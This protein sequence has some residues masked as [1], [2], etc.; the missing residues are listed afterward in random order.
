MKVV[1]AETGVPPKELPGSWPSYPEMFRRMFED[2]GAGF[3]Y[4]TYD[5]DHVAV[6]EPQ[7]GAALLVTGSPRGVYEDH[8]FIPRLE[9]SVR[10]WAGAGRPVVGICFGHQLVARAFGAKVEKSERGW[11]VGVHT[12]EVVGDAPWGEGPRRFACAVSHQDQVMGLAGGLTRIAGS[13]FTPY[14]CL[15]HEELPVL[16][17]Q[18]HPEFRHDFASALMALRSDRIPEERTSLAQASLRNE[19]DRMAIALWIKNFME[20]RN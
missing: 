3:T 13:A 7:E 14:G 1:I 11:G 12:Y 18:P 15:G 20:A 4:E 16:T 5:T 2:I 10:K 8:A 17:F 19:S 9:E 6:P